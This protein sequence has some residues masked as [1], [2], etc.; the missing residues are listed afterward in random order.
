MSGGAL[1]VFAAAEFKD[2]E[3][4]AAAVFLHGGADFGAGDS[5]VADGGGSVGEFGEDDLVE[6]GFVAGV[7]GHSVDEQ[8]VAGSRAVLRS[9]GG[10][11][12]D[13]GGARRG[14][15]CGGGFGGHVFRGRKKA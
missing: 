6:D 2:A 15:G 4:F 5:G 3:F 8:R 14:R 7:E 11:S 12:R 1:G 10:E 9:A 13:N